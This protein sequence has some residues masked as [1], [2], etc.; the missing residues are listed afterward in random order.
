MKAILKPVLLTTVLTIAAFFAVLYSSC[1]LDKCKAISCAYGGICID[2]ACACLPGYEGNNCETVSRKK[3]VSNFWQVSER[4]TISPTRQYPVAIEPAA[5]VNWVT[6]KNFYNF[7]SDNSV[8][9]YIEKDTI[10]IPNQQ[11][12]SKIIF[13]KGY[14]HS[15]S[16]STV[17]N[18]ITMR[19]VVVDA[20][21]NNIVDDFGY[22]SAINNSSPSVWY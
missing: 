10:T 15:T 3:F 20:N 13:G 9:A 4:G 8:R 22:Y 7:F 6:I 17:N 11:I 12:G 18:V 2:G 14:I 5:E 21:N 16:P 1:K 19:Y